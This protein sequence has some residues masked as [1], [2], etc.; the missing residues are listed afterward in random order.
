MRNTPLH[1]G[2][3]CDDA[4]IDLLLDDEWPLDDLLEVQLEPD[5]LAG[6][7]LPTVH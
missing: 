3:E 4:I 7:E 6:H 2:F 1:P 5:D